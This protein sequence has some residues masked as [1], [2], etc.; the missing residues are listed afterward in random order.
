MCNFPGNW[1]AW[2][3]RELA[4]EEAERMRQHL[5]SCAECRDRFHSYLQVTVELHAFCDEQFAS[6]SRGT[7]YRWSAAIL[8]AGAA[9]AVV[10]LLLLASRP[11]VQSP[12]PLRE[13]SPVSLSTAVVEN[14]SP[15]PS[16]RTERAHRN[17]SRASVRQPLGLSRQVVKNENALSM[18]YEPVIEISIPADEIFPPGA[19]PPGMHFAADLSISPDGSADRM[20]LQPELTGFER[21]TSIP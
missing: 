8:A 21:R 13:Q 6:K 9:A 19:V 7:D 3:D 11:R 4:P 10:A 18:P 5:E 17:Q 12:A 20:R 1:T 14:P 16:Q 15:A 2:M